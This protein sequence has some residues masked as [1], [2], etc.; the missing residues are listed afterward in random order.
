MVGR[1]PGRRRGQRLGEA[2]HGGV[3]MSCRTFWSLGLRGGTYMHVSI[4]HLLELSL[5]QPSGPDGNHPFLPHT[6]DCQVQE[7]E[8]GKE[9]GNACAV[10]DVRCGKEKG[11]GAQA[12]HVLCGT[13]SSMCGIDCSLGFCTASCS[14]SR[15]AHTPHVLCHAGERHC[16]A[17]LMQVLE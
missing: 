2:R 3:E 5:R 14:A 13:Q 15:P 6:N 7:G 10:G 12:T 8:K 16:L 17:S 11:G 1:R 9:A 4:L